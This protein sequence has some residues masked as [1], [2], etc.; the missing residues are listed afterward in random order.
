MSGCALP[1]R[2]AH[3]YTENAG[4]DLVH[5]ALLR[6]AGWRKL[7]D[8]ASRCDPDRSLAASMMMMMRIGSP[9]PFMRLSTAYRLDHPFRTHAA[10]GDGEGWLGQF[11]QNGRGIGRSDDCKIRVVEGPP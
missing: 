3:R 8:L 2:Q 7:S 6:T 1:W 10:K 11:P 4:H 9:S 5:G